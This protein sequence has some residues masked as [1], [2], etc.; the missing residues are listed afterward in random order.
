MKTKPFFRI[1][2]ILAIALLLASCGGGNTAP[3][4]SGGNKNLEINETSVSTNTVAEPIY[5]NNCGSIA[6]AEQISEHSQTITITGEA[7]IGVGNE[8][9]EASVGAKYAV[10]KGVTKSQKVIAAPG[11]NMEFILLWTEKV[12]EGSVT[13]S[14]N[15]GEATYHVSVPISV[16]Q[17]SAN[18]LGCG[19]TNTNTDTNSN[20][21]VL[22]TPTTIIVI[23][24][25]PP[26]GNAI[27]GALENDGT[28]AIDT[29][30]IG[31]HPRSHLDA[32][33]SLRATY[34][35]HIWVIPETGTAIANFYGLEPGTYVVCFGQYGS[36]VKVG[37][38]TV[39]AYKTIQQTFRWPP[40]YN[41]GSTCDLN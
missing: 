28:A 40:S 5:L 20:P 19:N 39:E 15:S 9:V 21:P 41:I 11:T 25:D 3:Q 1:E 32:A 34:E 6:N 22:P 2:I 29:S 14:G 35:D 33:G 10:A 8:I 17:A 18:D 36:W 12:S 4:S 27:I 24:T 38:I 23:P 30:N 37:E 31:L 13:V 7:Q 16:E 26:L